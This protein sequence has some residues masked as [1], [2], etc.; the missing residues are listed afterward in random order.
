MKQTASYVIFGH[1]NSIQIFLV[2]HVKQKCFSVHTWLQQPTAGT[3]TLNHIGMIKKELPL[4]TIEWGKG[5]S[6]HKL[7]LGLNKIVSDLHIYK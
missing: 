1:F 5:V 4:L 3:Q 6:K 7:R 2:I